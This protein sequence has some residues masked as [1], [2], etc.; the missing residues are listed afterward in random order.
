MG[1]ERIGT[2][3][4]R[5]PIRILLATLALLSVGLIAVTLVN[6][7]TTAQLAEQA[8]QNTGL[9]MALEVAAEARA[10]SAR[11]AAM[12][13]ALVAGQHRREIAF[14][15]IGE[16]DGTII[17]HTNPRLVGNRLDDAAYVH[18]RDTGRMVGEFV[19]LGTGEEVYELT[20]P[21]HIPPVGP[22]GLVD[23]SQPRFRIIRIALHTAP[24]RQIVYQAQ[25]QLLFVAVAVLV[26]TGLGAWQVRTLRR[27]FVLQQES[28]RQERFAAL[29]EMAAVLAHEIRNPLGAIKGL[30]QFL[31]E[32]QAADPQ[33]AEMTRTIAMRPP[34]WSGW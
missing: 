27:Y 7:R 9:G 11:D 33:Q 23:I 14:L 30:A 6:Y 26:L 12:L 17:A 4:S 31:G 20:A 19:V 28:A 34:G 3:A 15:A 25:A 5:W 32:K 24:A 13:Q 8:L 2:I 10:L 1:G 18:T 22:G 16:R 21:F 29:G